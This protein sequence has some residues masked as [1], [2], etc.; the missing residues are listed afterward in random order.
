MLPCLPRFRV[1]S[2]TAPRRFL[3]AVAQQ[4]VITHIPSVE[5]VPEPG[6]FSRAVIGGGHVYVSGVGGNLD[7]TGGVNTNDTTMGVAKEAHSALL[8]VERVLA[9]SGTTVDRVVT[10]TMLLTDKSD[11]A[12]ANRAYVAFFRER[13]LA[14]KLPARATAL[15]GVPTDARVAF[16]A[17]ALAASE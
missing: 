14:D 6:A 8:N 9:A 4:R 3:A 11:Y 7:D 10:I 12:A 15:W 2:G 13:G 17:V 16:S 1:C 5:G